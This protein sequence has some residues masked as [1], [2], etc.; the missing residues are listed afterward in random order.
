[1]WIDLSQPDEIIPAFGNKIILK[2]SRISLGSND[3]SS[4]VTPTLSVPV[5]LASS[6]SS[7]G[8]GAAQRPIQQQQQ[9]QSSINNKSVG[10]VQSKNDSNDLLG[11]FDSSSSSSSHTPAAVSRGSDSVGDLFATPLTSTISTQKQ[12]GGGGGGGSGAGF[13]VFGNSLGGSTSGYGV[14]Q[15][16]ISRG[17]TI[18]SATKGQPI[19]PSGKGLPI[20]G[21][22]ASIPAP[23]KGTTAGKGGGGLGDLDIFSM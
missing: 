15:T 19:G 16:G 3:A 8:N 18:S 12:Q 5:S 21:A 13:D 17:S 9:Q 22:N 10:E 1:V 11:V 2:V 14:G 4:S 7:S 6:A 20:G 23:S